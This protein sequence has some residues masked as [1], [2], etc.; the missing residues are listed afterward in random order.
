MSVGIWMAPSEVG[1]PAMSLLSGY[2]LR[3]R[4]ATQRK[5]NYARLDEK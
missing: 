4:N 2:M 5:L 1:L 3:I